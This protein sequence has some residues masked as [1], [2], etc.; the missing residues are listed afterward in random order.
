VEHIA[1]ALSVMRDL[2]VEGEFTIYRAAELCTVFQEAVAHGTD[3]DVHLDAVSEIDSAGIQLLLSAQRSIVAHRRELRI[4]SMSEAVAHVLA[5]FG[6]VQQ[7]PMS[8]DA[9][10]ARSSC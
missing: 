2:V 4:A 6:L 8:P 10:A 9:V 3:L 7:F 5:E 1:D